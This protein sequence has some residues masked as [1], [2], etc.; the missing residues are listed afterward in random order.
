MKD[1]WANP[2][3]LAKILTVSYQFA[4][5]VDVPDGYTKQLLIDLPQWRIYFAS[6]AYLIYRRAIQLSRYGK[7]TNAGMM[8]LLFAVYLESCDVFITD[9]V[10]QRRALRILSKVGRR[11]PRVQSYDDFRSRLLPSSLQH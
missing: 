7:N 4:T 8:D 3:E 9:D 2:D 11:R 10:Q 1:H 6:W 5:G